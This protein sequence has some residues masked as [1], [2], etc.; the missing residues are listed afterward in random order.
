MSALPAAS[1]EVLK[2]IFSPLP[3]KGGGGEPKHAQAS[4]TNFFSRTP[5]RGEQP[6]T[7]QLQEE[8]RESADAAEPC[9]EVRQLPGVSDRIT[10]A[11]QA[12]AK[13]D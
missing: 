11:P 13:N 8:P 4:I 1:K 12:E 2:H 5:V 9:V 6:A 7:Q 10:K 3:P